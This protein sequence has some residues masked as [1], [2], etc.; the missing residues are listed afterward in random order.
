M[1]GAGDGL[2]R[3][4]DAGRTWQRTLPLI[5]E[6]AAYPIGAAGNGVV[7][8]TTVVG[9]GTTTLHVSEDGLHWHDVTPLMANGSPADLFSEAVLLESTAPDAIGFAYPGITDQPDMGRGLLRTEDGGRHWGTIAGTDDVTGLTQV[10]GSST[11]FAAAASGSAPP[12]CDGHLIRS[13]DNGLR[14]ST[15]ANS[16]T[17]QNLFSVDFLDALHGF[18]A[19]GT[20]NHYG[21][22]QLLLA[23]EDGGRTWQQRFSTGTPGGGGEQFPDGFAQVRFRTLTDGLALSGACVGG[24]DG[25]CGGSLWRTTDGGHS[26][27]DTGLLGVDLSAVGGTA[28]L[29]GLGAV[30]AGLSV[31]TD[32]GA[33][34]SRTLAAADRTIWQLSRTQAGLTAVTND[35]VDLSADGGHTWQS[36]SLP[37]KRSQDFDAAVAGSHGVVT[38]RGFHLAWQSTATSTSVAAQGI[39]TDSSVQIGHVA[40]GADDDSGGLAVAG[41]QTTDLCRTDVFGS[42]DGGRSWSTRGALEITVDGPIGYDGQ[43][44]AAI[45]DCTPTGAIDTTDMLAVSAD[46]GRT[47]SLRRSKAGYDLLAASVSG[48]AVWVMGADAKG[49]RLVLVSR[50]AGLTWT[51]NEL[52]GVTA[53][54]IESGTVVAVSADEA[55]LSDGGSTLWRTTDSGATWR[56]ERPSLPTH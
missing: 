1:V 30:D 43:L 6:L 4:A 48:N 26:W 20:P 37:V 40:L 28:T 17:T 38:S 35:G 53:P 55:L 36:L 52:V 21:G 27:H 49:N 3:S 31:S 46:G 14:W 34:W 2:W 10:P 33:T 51:A 19:G 45:G 29:T 44:A 7:A 47:W 50:D 42:R 13:D 5:G 23:T 25:P 24:A 12:T 56:Q 22:S 16:C 11:L 32:G 9:P 8:A 39:P 41:S 54:L 18:A 15:V